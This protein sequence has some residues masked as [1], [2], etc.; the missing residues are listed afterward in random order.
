[1]AIYESGLVNKCVLPLPPSVGMRIKDQSTQK[2]YEITI[3]LTDGLFLPVDASIPKEENSDQN[4]PSVYISLAEVNEFTG[5]IN[6]GK[7]L[8]PSPHLEVR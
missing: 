8:Y 6:H 5:F 4:W 3:V 1:M 7:T 2:S